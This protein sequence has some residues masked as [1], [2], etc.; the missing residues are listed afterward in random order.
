VQHREGPGVS[1]PPPHV[2]PAEPCGDSE[3]IRRIGERDLEAF[4]VLY[5]RFVRPVLGLSLR[6]LGDRGRAERAT[7]ETFSAIWRSAASYRPERGPGAPW[8][9][10]VARN[11]IVNQTR[12][13]SEPGGNAVEHIESDW[14]RWRV[15]RAL[16]GLPEDQRA[17]I[18]LAYWSELSQSEIA[19]QL[20]IPLGTI[21]T[22]TRRA[23]ACLDKQLGDEE[24]H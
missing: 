14:S 17:L 12:K 8:L 15:H 9:Y 2:S 20:D 23:L 13:H 10:A 6:K 4:E 7:K 22:R 19:T 5:R 18:D 24:L 3:L 16:E 21:K 11:T 1:R